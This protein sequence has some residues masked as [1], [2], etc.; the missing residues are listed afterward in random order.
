MPEDLHESLTPFLHI[1]EEAFPRVPEGEERRAA[2]AA[3]F[4]DMSEEALAAL[5]AAYF[6]DGPM[7]ILDEAIHAVTDR[8]VDD[9]LVA[10]ARRRLERAGWPFEVDE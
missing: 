6:N 2:L 1:L 10:V 5:G 9:Q 7:V 8:R 4:Y 3:L